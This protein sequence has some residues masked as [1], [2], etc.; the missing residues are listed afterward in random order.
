PDVSAGEGIASTSYDGITP[1]VHQV[2][3]LTKDSQSPHHDVHD[4]TAVVR[5]DVMDRPARTR[6]NLRGR[7]FRLDGRQHLADPLHHLH[8]RLRRV[9]HRDVLPSVD[10]PM[11]PAW[12]TKQT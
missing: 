11:V 9:D 1:L 8:V 2:Q 3:A 10:E 12:L 6:W 4:D 7:P 5:D